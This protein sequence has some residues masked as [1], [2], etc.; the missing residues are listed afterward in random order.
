M[1]PDWARATRPLVLV[2]TAICFLVTILFKADV[3]AQGGAYATGV[4]M[5]MTSAAVAV[6]ISAWRKSEKRW[7]GFLIITIVFV[8]TTV[9]NMIEQPSGIKIASLFIVGII[10]SS[11]VSRA[12]RTTEVRVE[13]FE[14]DDKAKEFIDEMAEGEIR[15]V[16]NRRETGDVA[17]YR[18][19]EHEKR[20]DNHIPSSDPIVFYEI[21]PGDASEFTGKLFVRG[22]DVDGY[23][24]L[25]TEAPAVPNA[26]AA[27]LLHLRDKTGKIPHVYFGWSEGNPASYLIRYILFGE[28]DTA[29]VTREILRQAE[30]NPEL[31]PSVHVGG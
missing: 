23:K 13:G 21:T 31:R 19:K 15:I 7:I 29:P 10:L 12:L 20:V 27:L 4:L 14:L 25:R 24:I 28:G 1:A 26:I 9:V 17:E 8:Y 2:F 22:V 30:P 11:F 16:T 18:F 6:T 3:T 5:L